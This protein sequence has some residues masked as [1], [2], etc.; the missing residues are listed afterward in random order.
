MQKYSRFCI[1]FLEKKFSEKRPLISHNKRATDYKNE[2]TSPSVRPRLSS[3]FQ[4]NTEETSK[5]MP[6][7]VGRHSQKSFSTSNKGGTISF[8]INK[9]TKHSLQSIK[10]NN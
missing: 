2:S 8:G 10:H 9:V 3:K 4:D 6:Q 5:F 1:C 7:S